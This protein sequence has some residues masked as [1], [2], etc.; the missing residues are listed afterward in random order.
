VRGNSLARFLEGETAATPSLYSA[1]ISLYLVAT[2][3]VGLMSRNLVSGSSNSHHTAPNGGG[4]LLNR[5]NS[6]WLRLCS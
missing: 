6:G 2:Q 1:Q 3:L 5:P 4:R